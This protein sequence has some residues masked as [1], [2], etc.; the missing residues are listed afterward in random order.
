[1]TTCKEWFESNNGYD[2]RGELGIFSKALICWL[3]ISQRLAGGSLQDGLAQVVQEHKEGTLSEL[4]KG[5]GRK[6]KAGNISAHTGGVSRAR[7]RISVDS[8]KSL[9]DVATS[10]LCGELNLDKSKCPVYVLDGQVITIAR[11]QT[12][13]ESFGRTTNGMGELHYPRVRA[14]SV[15]EVRSGI[16]RNV[17]VGKWTEHETTIAQRVLGE[18]PNGAI[19]VMDRG[20]DKPFFIRFARERG[21]KVIVRVK[22]SLGNKLL[23]NPKESNYSKQVEWKSPSGKF[24]PECESGRMIKYTSSIKGFRSSEFF[25]FTTADDL[26]DSE[27]ADLYRQRVRVE[28]FIRDIKQTLRMFFVSSKKPD[29]VEK[30]IIIAYLTFN[31]LRAI[32]ENTASALGLPV[33]RM[34]F[35]STKRLISVYDGSF[36]AAKTKEEFEEVLARFREHMNQSKLPNRKKPRSYPRVIKYPRDKYKAEGIFKDTK[37]SLE[38]K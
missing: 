5:G 37:D 8:V 27:I 20:F 15:H 9:F 31:L 33:E 23:S 28:I 16:A 7:D 10:N 34:S 32:M 22:N 4:V 2:V 26:S 17:A 11:S 6:V 1:M 29:N 25:F 14:V 35:T 18:L 19:V 3:V 21:L 13:I 12:N 24:G 30:D 38:G 36:L